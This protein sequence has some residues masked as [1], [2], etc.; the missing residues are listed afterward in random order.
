MYAMDFRMGIDFK[1]KKMQLILTKDRIRNLHSGEKTC[2]PAMGS[3]VR[4]PE[5][6][7][8]QGMTVLVTIA[9]GDSESR[10][11]NQSSRSNTLHV[12]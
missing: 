7:Q 9:L 6:T 11:G 4:F 5:S 2:Y 1:S 8:K 3:A 12:Q 10:I